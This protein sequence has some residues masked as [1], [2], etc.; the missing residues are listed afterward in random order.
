MLARADVFIQNLA[1]GKVEALGFDP[2]RLRAENPRLVTCSISGYGEEGPYRDLK[3]YDLLVQAESGLSAITGTPD[4][5]ARVGV[6]GLRHRGGHD[7]LPGH[8][9]GADRT[10]D[11]RA[12]PARS[13]CR[14]STRSRTG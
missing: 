2:A 4:G 1:P 6:L 14:C 11:R 8:P 12:W 7:C 10:G 3:A 13:R 9:A 5:M